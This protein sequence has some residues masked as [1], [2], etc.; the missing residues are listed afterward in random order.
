[1]A[2]YRAGLWVPPNRS[3]PPLAD[4]HDA[5]GII[6]N[7]KMISSKRPSKAISPVSHV[8]LSPNGSGSI[9]PGHVDT[10]LHPLLAEYLQSVLQNQFPSPPSTGSAPYQSPQRFMS[11]A[12][13]SD[14]LQATNTSYQPLENQ[15][16]TIPE[17]W[18]FLAQP[19]IIDPDIMA[20]FIPV[21]SVEEVPL[22]GGRTV[23]QTMNEE[24]DRFMRGL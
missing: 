2:Q 7:M 20:S 6:T 5:P 12:I 17:Q 4:D 9:S 16:F 11:T 13:S 15:S 23:N 8:G 18:N 19:E 24:W 21:S 10:T 22:V 3:G 1:M 14:P